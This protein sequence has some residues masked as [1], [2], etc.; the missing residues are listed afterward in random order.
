MKKH[1]LSRT[2][3]AALI[4]LGIFSTAFT[5]GA[6]LKTSRED[7]FRLGADPAPNIS[8]KAAKFDGSQYVW[9]AQWTSVDPSHSNS[10]LFGQ[11]FD[12]GAFDVNGGID[13]TA[14]LKAQCQFGE[15]NNLSSLDA[16]NYGWFC[17]RIHEEE[18]LYFKNLGVRYDRDPY[19]FY[20]ANW[21]NN[22]VDS[23][24][25]ESQFQGAKKDN[26]TTALQ[27][28]NSVLPEIMKLEG[29]WVTGSAPAVGV[30]ANLSGT[31]LHVL[32]ADSPKR[33]PFHGDALDAQG[34]AMLDEDGYYYIYFCV[35]PDLL[36][37]YNFVNNLDEFMPCYLSFRPFRVEI[38]VRT[39]P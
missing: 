19:V 5:V 16:S 39:K 33:G 6:W 17:L 25:S 8:I 2:A 12:P 38:D 37:Y 21:V 29:P 23:I 18:G 11:D 28:A 14:R 24:L 20:G 4:L 36:S 3:A 15:I 32:T 27:K 10:S 22:K 13:A 26:L 1:K 31:D 7:Q 30:P 9:D 34:A 35:Y